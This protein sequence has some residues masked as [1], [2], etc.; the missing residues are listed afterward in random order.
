MSEAQATAAAAATDTS[1]QAPA[2]VAAVNGIVSNTATNI[3]VAAPSTPEADPLW[4]AGRLEQAKRALLREMGVDKPDD[5]KAALADLKA[6]KDAEKS[7][8]ERIAAKL[9]DLE[10]KAKRADALEAV[11]AIRATAELAG[12]SEVQRSTVLGLAGDDPA[13]QLRHIEA[14]RPTWAALPEAPKP[15]AAPANTAPAPAAPPQ[16]GSAGQHNHKAKWEELKKSDPM[17][18]AHYLAAHSAAIFPNQ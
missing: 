11:V 7:E 2:I 1:I 18:A 12:L 4:L 10:S 6:R 9:A 8:Q 13:S 16:T 3:P 5:V 15:I 14:L 17:Q